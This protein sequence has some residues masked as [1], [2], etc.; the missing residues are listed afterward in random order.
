[1]SLDAQILTNGIISFF[2]FL[3]MHVVVFW[4]VDAKGV[5]KWLMNIL[6]VAS[7]LNIISTI[8]F[9]FTQPM[10]L[11][12]ALMA[13]VLSLIIFGILAFLYI[14]CIFGPFESSIRMRLIHEL[15]LVYP[16]GLTYDAMLKR[17]N[18]DMMLQRRL[19]RL[20]VSGDLRQEGPLYLP[21]KRFNFFLLKES[22]GEGI[23]KITGF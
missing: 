12:M 23:R 9:A 8:R 6:L 22:L 20:T 4:F 10:G 16:K 11:P 17:Y 3:A 15:S 21:G 5:L 1:M 19:D 13:G 2:V 7:M 14:L 18:A